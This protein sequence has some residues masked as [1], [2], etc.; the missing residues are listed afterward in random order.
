MSSYSCY[1][2]NEVYRLGAFPDD[3]IGMPEWSALIESLSL[4][5]ASPELA[6]SH[7][8]DLRKLHAQRSV[9]LKLDCP[10][11]FISHRQSDKST[12]LSIAWLA[13]SHRFDY[14]LDILDPDIAAASGFPES[15]QK[16]VLMAAIIEMALLNSTHVVAVMT[17]NV[18]GTMWMP[19]EYGRIKDSALV[20]VIA[21][22]WFD[23]SWQPLNTPE[24]FH[25]GQQFRRKSEI[26]SWLTGEILNWPSGTCADKNWPLHYVPE[27]LPED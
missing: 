5:Q 10:R 21:S 1:N 27:S 24:Y 18:L 2:E 16:A 19:Y 14:W 15:Y 22:G 9:K 17:S 23:S 13:N 26:E 6:E 11:L 7:L 4:P 8:A 20:S 3:A 25:L 12:A